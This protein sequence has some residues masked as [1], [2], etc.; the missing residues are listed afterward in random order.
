MSGSTESRS[1]RQYAP[2]PAAPYREHGDERPGDPEDVLVG[3]YLAEIT[4][5]A[6]AARHLADYGNRD[7][8]GQR[9]PLDTAERF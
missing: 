3:D 2:G 9:Y 8:T 4:L 6:L 7:R 1:A 5:A